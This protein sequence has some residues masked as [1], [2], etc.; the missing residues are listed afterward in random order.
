MRTILFAALFFLP[1]WLT[2]AGGFEVVRPVIAQSDGGTPVP[3]SFEHVAGETL[4]FSCRVAG[5]SK[6]SDDK[7]H[8]TYAVQAFDPK[9]VPLGESYK[10]EIMTDVSPQDKERMPNIATEV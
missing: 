7:V 1:A 6:S 10:N 9:G 8:V 5:Y 4:Y 3:K 2:G